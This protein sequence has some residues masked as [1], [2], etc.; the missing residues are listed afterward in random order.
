MMLG[1]YGAALIGF[2]TTAVPEWTDTPRLRGPALFALAGLWGMGRLAGLL[3]GDMLAAVAAADLLWL[4]A[5]V[6]YVARCWARKPQAQL[7][8]PL[9]WLSLLSLAVYTLLR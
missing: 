5:L 7:F 8:G 2:I 3:G 4:A 9:L 1:T 6:T